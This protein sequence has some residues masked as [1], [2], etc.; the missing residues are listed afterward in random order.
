MKDQLLSKLKHNVGHAGYLIDKNGGIIKAGIKEI[1]ESKR[2]VKYLNSMGLYELQE[3]KKR[4]DL[5]EILR[6]IEN[7]PTY[8][9]SIRFDQIRN[10]IFK[11]S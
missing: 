10:F 4:T 9:S 5:V 7:N 3:A 1:N 11:L 6:P 8:I 2:T